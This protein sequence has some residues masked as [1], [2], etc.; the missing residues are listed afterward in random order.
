MPALIECV[1]NFSEGRNR[2]TIAALE[3]A[4]SAVPEVRLLDVHVDADHHRSVFTLVGRP[5][6][7][8]DAAVRAVA[9]AVERIDLRLHRGEHPRMGAADVVPFVPLDGATLGDCATLAREV[10]ARIGPELG[11]PVYLYGRAATRPDRVSLPNVRARGFEDLLERV[12]RDPLVVPDFGPPAL[13][14]TAGATAVGARPLLVAFNVLLAT[15]DVRVAQRVA[16][17]VRTSGGG[18]PS[19]QARGFLVRGRAQV[20][21]NLLDVDVTPPRAAVDAIAREAARHGTEIVSSEIVGLAPER[22]LAGVS[23]ATLH[24]QEPATERL[25]EPRLRALGA[26]LAGGAEPAA[27]P[28]ASAAHGEPER[29]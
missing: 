7:V 14:P 15:T 16:R 24:L 10:G 1:P 11:V 28:R 3:R 29:D 19:V 20:S 18:L 9:V 6:A 27:P 4:V 17:A 13:H 12:G 25:L 2:N 21:L 26:S 5:S 23:A 8:A 22:A